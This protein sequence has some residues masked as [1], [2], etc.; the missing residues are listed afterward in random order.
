MNDLVGKR[1]GRLTVIKRVDKPEEKKQSRCY[2]LCSCD[3]GNIKVTN[4]QDLGRKH[5]TSCGCKQEEN[6]KA[7]NDSKRKDLKGMVFGRLLVIEQAPT[8]KQST[9]WLCKCECGKEKEINAQSLM[10]GDTTSCGCYQREKS[11]GAYGESTF[12]RTYTTYKQHAKNRNLDFNLTKDRFLELT[13]KECFYCGKKSSNITKSGFDNGDFVYNGIDRLDSSKGYVEENIV[14][15]CGRCNEAKMAETKEDFL[16]WV[17]SVYNHSI[18][19]KQ[20]TFS[21]KN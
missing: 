17:A 13:Q 2:W 8:K 12:N 4:S 15:C 20:D 18:V 21:T 19:K 10:N 16:E 9:Y 7:L 11:R 6:R 1:F 14:P 3:C 5:T